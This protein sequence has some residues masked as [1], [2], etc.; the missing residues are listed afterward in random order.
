M[1]NANPSGEPTG[2][3]L[4]VQRLAALVKRR[5]E[6][7]G[8]TPAP[9]NAE[10]P[11][12]GYEDAASVLA[13]FEPASLRPFGEI[14]DDAAVRKNL[15]DQLLVASTL[16]TDA[17]GTTRWSLRP[18]RRVAR[19]KALRLAGTARQA[20]AANP[21]RPEEATQTALTLGLLGKP[22]PIQ[23]ASLLDLKAFLEV[24][25]W[26]QS[27]GIQ[28]SPSAAEISSRI[29]WRTLLQPFDHLA[30][31]NFRGRSTPQTGRHRRSPARCF[32]NHPKSPSWSR[33]RAAWASRPS[34]R[35]SS[36]STRRRMKR[37]ASH[38]PT[39]TSTGPTSSPTSRSRC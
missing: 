37:I 7:A 36:S 34:S 33:A 20:L 24:A 10:L 23:D 21:I 1:T 27:A 26:L 39:W 30:G 3:K 32:A 14:R 22:L 38:S 17:A 19:L 2:L 16:V 15:L 31:D 8:T 4:D 18:A 5:L 13:W 11:E 35:D 12:N 25:N 29:D 6:D 28:V 9:A